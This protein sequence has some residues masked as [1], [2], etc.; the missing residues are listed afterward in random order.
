M[1]TFCWFS[2]QNQ[3]GWFTTGRIREAERG[4]GDEPT[5]MLREMYS[6]H[7]YEMGWAPHFKAETSWHCPTSVTLSDQTPSELNTRHFMI[8]NIPYDTRSQ[9]YI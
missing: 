8:S 6:L 1:K 2:L 7:A 5:L 4:T 9:S 3:G